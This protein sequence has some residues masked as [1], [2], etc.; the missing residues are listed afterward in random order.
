MDVWFA[1]QRGGA[2]GLGNPQPAIADITAY[3]SAVY[4]IRGRL[5][6]D[7]VPTTTKPD[8]V[9]TVLPDETLI[10]VA[11]AVGPGQSAP[12]VTVGPDCRDQ[13]IRGG[14][15]DPSDQHPE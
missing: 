5:D 12:D 3:R 15:V 14:A 2:T 1:G 6:A 10:R 8:V 4:W 13:R 11:R 9:N 7:P